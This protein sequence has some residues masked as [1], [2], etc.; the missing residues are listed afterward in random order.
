MKTCTKCR[1]A[2]PLDEFSRNKASRDGRRPDCK[3]CWSAYRAANRARIRERGREYYGANREKFRIY[4]AANPH[5]GWEASYAE[6]AR[7]I[8]FAPLVEHFTREELITRYGDQCFHC[9]GPFEELD[10]YPVPVAH[11]GAHTL[12]NTK[13]ACLKCNRAQSN[14]IRYSRKEIAA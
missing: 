9:G 1:E 8:G 7:D 12:D 5:I 3:E 11:G 10:H 14:N 6:R 13:P 4:R 2:K